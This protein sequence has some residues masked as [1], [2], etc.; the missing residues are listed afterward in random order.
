M[1]REVRGAGGALTCFDQEKCWLLTD[2][3]THTQ[4]RLMCEALVS[5]LRCGLSRMSESQEVKF[6]SLS[7]F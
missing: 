1:K 3:H 4:T 6:L 5:V 7:L 2:F